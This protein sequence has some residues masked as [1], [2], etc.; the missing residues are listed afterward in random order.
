MEL[1]H[2]ILALVVLQR[3]GELIYAS[4][5]TRA[6]KRRGG[7][8]YGRRH[9]PLIVLLHASWLTA[10]AIGIR[11]DPAVRTVPLTFFVLLQ[12]LRVWVLATLGSCWTTRVITI[13]GAPLVQRGP[14][15]FLSHPNYLVIV[16]EMAL[17]PLAFGQVANAIIFSILNGAALAW[18]IRVE[19]AA[20]GPRRRQPGAT[21]PLGDV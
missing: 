20:L 21:L 15:R 18:R 12:G 13:P 11:R 14:Y 19:E 7:I 2:A 8:E 1:A 5:N 3:V 9:Y 6:L 17:L 16:G 10:I 4:S